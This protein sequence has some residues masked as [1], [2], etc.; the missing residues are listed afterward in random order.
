MKDY[1][2]RMLRTYVARPR[3]VY[4]YYYNFESKR[5]MPNYNIPPL[6]RSIRVTDL[7]GKP[8]ILSK[9][10]VQGGDYRYVLPLQQ[11]LLNLFVKYCL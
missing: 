5:M 6:G 4:D 10:K 11:F 7:T 8:I 3:P 2:A 1:G 9:R